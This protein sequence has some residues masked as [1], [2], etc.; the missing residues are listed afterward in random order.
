MQ[1]SVN[2]IDQTLK[3]RV[4]GFADGL[5]KSISVANNNVDKRVQA[6]S[7]HVDESLM[8]TIK[9]TMTDSGT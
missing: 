9:V 1:A 3:S 5:N 2:N 4:D 6:C 7:R 8:E